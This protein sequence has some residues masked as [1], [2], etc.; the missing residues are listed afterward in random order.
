MSLSR[1]RCSSPRI[2]PWKFGW[3]KPSISSCT[4]PMVISFLLA[5]PWTT[6]GPWHVASGGSPPARYELVRLSPG[7]GD[8]R[9]EGCGLVLGPSGWPEHPR[10]CVD[11]LVGVDVSVSGR[12]LDGEGKVR[13]DLP[14]GD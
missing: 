5:Q 10:P 14:E 13:G 11:V 9:P 7:W 12:D 4:G 1:R 6:P 2:S 8:D 3:S